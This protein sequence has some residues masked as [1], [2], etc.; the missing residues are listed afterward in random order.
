MVSYVISYIKAI[1]SISFITTCGGIFVEN[2]RNNLYVLIMD[3]L[4]RVTYNSFAY[5]V[6]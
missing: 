5:K 2:K 4:S 1:L 6:C 3:N